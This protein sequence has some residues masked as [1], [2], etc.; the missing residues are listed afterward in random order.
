[1]SHCLA[2]CCNCVLINIQKNVLCHKFACA[3]DI[4]CTTQAETF[5]ELECTLTADLV[6]VTQ[7]C[8]RWRFEAKHLKDCVKCVPPAEH[9][10]KLPTECLDEWRSVK[11]RPESSI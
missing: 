9:L 2:C 6:R 5:A 7:Y 3:D 11:A 4:C 10:G 1:V 8:Q